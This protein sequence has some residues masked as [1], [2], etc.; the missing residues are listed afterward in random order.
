MFGM[1]CAVDGTA[2]SAA[3]QFVWTEK[4]G[5]TA[6]LI[7]IHCIFLF[8]MSLMA[9]VMKIKTFIKNAAGAYADHRIELSLKISPSKWRQLI[10]LACDQFSIRNFLAGILILREFMLLSMWN[11]SGRRSHL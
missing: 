2:E 4:R 11:L 5:G 7:F 1:V 10:K 6:I 8:D 3:L 9:P